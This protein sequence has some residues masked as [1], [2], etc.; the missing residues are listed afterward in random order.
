MLKAFVYRRYL[1]YGAFEELRSLKLQISQELRR[2]DRLENIKLGPGGIREIEFIGQAFQVI[3]GGSEK[4]LQ[5]RGIVD[6]LTLLGELHLLTSEDAAQLKQSYQFLR[7]AENHLQQYQDKQTHDLPTDPKVRQILAYSLDYADW[8]S[9]KRDLDQVRNQ[10]QAVFDQVFSVT[11]QTQQQANS[12]KI[13]LCMSDDS[14]LLQLLADYGFQEGEQSL[15]TLKHFKN[16]LAMKRLTTKGVGVL[17]RLMPQLIEALPQTQNPDTTLKRAL[18]LFEAVA[19]RNVY[20]SL[21][22]ENPHALAQLLRL[23]S[24]SPWFGDYL[25]RYPILFDDLLDPRTLF[26]PLDKTDLDSQLT[27]LLAN[28]DSDDEESLMNALRQFKQQQVL[29]VAAA[30]IMGIIPLMVVS[31][32]LT[33]IAETIVSHVLACAWR[34]LIAKHGCPPDCKADDNSPVSG[35]AVVGFGKLGGIELGYG[36]DLDMVFLYRC[37]DGNADTTGTKPIT[38]AQFYGKLGLKVRHILDT[39]LLSGILYDVDMRLR[40]HGDSGLLVTNIDVYEQYLRA[41]AWTWEH[42][43]L[44]RGR[45]IAGDLA[46]KAGFEAIRQRILS[47]PRDVA[48]LKSEVRA[49][50]QKM[51]GHLTTKEINKFDLKQSKGGIADIEFIVQFAVLALAAD[52]R[53]LSI[54]TDNI[55]LLAALQTQGFM[56]ADVANTLKT[57]YCAYRDA[58][59][60]L[61]LQGDNAVVDDAQVAELSSAVEHIWHRF[62][63]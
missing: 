27:A 1:D 38:C 21:L 16:S 45:F 52:N 19:G 31:D 2:K 59:H 12:Q 15:M 42:Q 14:E 13:W 40:P 41:E 20:L 56:A 48:A 8:H 3:R 29:R 55:R 4:R 51:R 57:A 37:Q 44:V 9:F 24:A 39:K 23:L 6:V 63:E 60:K 53:P 22:G 30:D 17:N 5:T 28:V 46:L 50:R 61:A 47:L 49:M 36:S 25:S 11:K 54:F 7:R 35:F 34:S 18:A 10:V 62:M 43:A 33:W 32:Y 58:G 26:E